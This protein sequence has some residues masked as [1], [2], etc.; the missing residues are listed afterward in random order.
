MKEALEAWDQ[1]SDD[2][3]DDGSDKDG[4]TEKPDV[5]V[6]QKFKIISVQ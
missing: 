5:P 3:S 1:I 2:G 4:G 6:T